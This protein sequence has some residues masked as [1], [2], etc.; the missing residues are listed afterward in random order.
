VRFGAVSGGR[1]SRL[2]GWAVSA[3]LLIA[4][5][6][7]AGAEPLALEIASA[8]VSFDQRTSEPVVSYRLTDSS[9]RRF[10]E[11]TA[12]NVGRKTE[13]RVDGRTVMTPV[14]REPILGGFGQISGGFNLDQAKDIA[15][16][17]SAGTAKVEIELVPN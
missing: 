12:Q 11:F 2:R 17:L 3:G 1:F 14:I 13:F 6:A 5:I 4:S 15:K 8:Q 10:A 7:A 9:A 16:R